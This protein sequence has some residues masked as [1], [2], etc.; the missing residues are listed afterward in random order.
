MLNQREDGADT[1]FQTS[2][3]SGLN[4]ASS[5]CGP[6]PLSYIRLTVAISRVCE[7][8]GVRYGAPSGPNQPAV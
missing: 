8:L 5:P 2:V 3:F 1:I 7:R 4:V 6:D